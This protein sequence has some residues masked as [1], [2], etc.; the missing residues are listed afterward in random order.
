MLDGLEVRAQGRLTEAL[1]R[2]SDSLLFTDS[3][4]SPSRTELRLHGFKVAT[5]GSWTT[6]SCT[7]MKMLSKHKDQLQDNSR[8]EERR[9]KVALRCCNNTRT[10]IITNRVPVLFFLAEKKM[11]KRRFSEGTNKYGTLRCINRQIDPPT[12]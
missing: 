11:K 6:L 1:R 3:V 4:G 7:I 12:D 8:N 10:S 9:L 5:Y 2:R